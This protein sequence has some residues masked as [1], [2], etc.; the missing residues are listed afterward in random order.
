MKS[1]Q[2]GIPLTDLSSSV[3]AS[4]AKA[5]TAIQQHQDISGKVDK[6]SFSYDSTT[7]TLTIT[8]S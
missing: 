7:E 1:H 4:L 5:D 6:T 3:Q 2:H 8:I